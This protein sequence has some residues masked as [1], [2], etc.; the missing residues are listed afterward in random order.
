VKASRSG[1]ADL[2]EGAFDPVILAVRQCACKRQRRHLRGIDLGLRHRVALGA[3]PR[4]HV[5]GAAPRLEY[6]F[7]RRSEVAG[8]DERFRPRGGRDVGLDLSYAAIAAS[9]FCLEGFQIVAQPV[10][11]MLP[12][13]SAGG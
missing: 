9:L 5:L 8:D 3:E 4:L 1:R 2:V 12:L 7:A 6:E 10:E 11:P 13:G